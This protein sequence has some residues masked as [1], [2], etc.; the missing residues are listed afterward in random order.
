MANVTGSGKKTA[1][2]FFLIVLIGTFHFLLPTETHTSHKIHIILRKLYYLPPV[3]AGAWFGLRGAFYVTLSTSILFSL[4]VFLDW[5]GNYME[6]ANQMGELLSFWVIGLV[7]GYLFDRQRHLLEEVAKANGDTLLAL[8][9]A[10]DL[11]ERN[12]RMHSQRVRDYAL[13][14]ADRFGVGEEEKRIIGFGALLH[15][16][17]KIAVSDNILLKSGELSETEWQSMR[18]HPSAG[19]MI[20]KRIGFLKEAAEIVHSHHEHFDG[21]G[22]PGGLKGY[23][24]PLGAR[25]FMVV[26]VYDALTNDR[27]YHVSMSHEEAVAVIQGKSGSHFDPAV[28]EVFLAIGKRELRAIKEQ[29]LENNYCPEFS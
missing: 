5:P 23:E 20:M 14:L 26:D 11:R 9:S 1:F 2:L 15:D 12:T 13:L 16:V 8:V 27:P 21:T 25:I 24:I 6:Q 7:S 4:H 18:R 19:Y 28:V 3:M 17:G 10:L 29:Y 22:Y